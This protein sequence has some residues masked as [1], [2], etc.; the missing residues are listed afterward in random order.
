[1]GK[2]YADTY[3][4]Y[5]EQRNDLRGRAT[6]LEAEI[7]SHLTNLRRIMELPEGESTHRGIAKN[8]HTQEHEA[9]YNALKGAMQEYHDIVGTNNPEYRDTYNELLR[10]FNS[11]NTGSHPIIDLRHMHTRNFWPLTQSQMTINAEN[12]ARTQGQRTAQLATPNS[13]Q[14]LWQQHLSTISA[15]PPRN[16]DQFVLVL[17]NL[18]NMMESNPEVARI[19]L[20]Y[21]ITN[22]DNWIKEMKE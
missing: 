18:N 12:L 16:T 21:C 15:N 13:P 8:T 20:E 14:N 9:E 7:R 2:E 6:G 4:G 10:E 5:E 22:G 19:L 17:E 3:E 1:M 11:L